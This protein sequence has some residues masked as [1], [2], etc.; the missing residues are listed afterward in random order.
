MQEP[1]E[2]KVKLRVTNLWWFE[3]EMRTI[4]MRAQSALEVLAKGTQSSK[5]V[6]TYEY[7]RMKDEKLTMICMQQGMTVSKAG[8]EAL[9]AAATVNQCSY[10]DRD[11]LEDVREKSTEREDFSELVTA[12]RSAELAENAA[13]GRVYVVM[14]E[15]SKIRN[16]HEAR[17]LGMDVLLWRA[18]GETRTEILP[19]GMVAPT[20]RK[21]EDLNKIVESWL[22]Y[23]VWGTQHHSQKAVGVTLRIYMA[24]ETERT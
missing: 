14:G 24:S 20:A 23:T 21:A 16:A 8:T 15:P 7:A 22:Q 4:D 2:E 13:V 5:S 18:Q 1:L 10:T 6:R 17:V 12:A 9:A 3:N 19:E 11:W